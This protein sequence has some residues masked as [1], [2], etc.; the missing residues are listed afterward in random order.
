LE[1]AAGVAVLKNT[2]ARQLSIPANNAVRW[3]K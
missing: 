3:H 1:K 2:F